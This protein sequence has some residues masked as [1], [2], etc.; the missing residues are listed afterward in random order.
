ML[1][2]PNFKMKSVLEMMA[3]DEIPS[4]G[5]ALDLEGDIGLY[6]FLLF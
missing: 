3:H 6:K 2:A 1:V 4:S 5:V